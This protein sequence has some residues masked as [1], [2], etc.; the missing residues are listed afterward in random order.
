VPVEGD[1]N[2]VFHK[3]IHVRGLSIQLRRR[4]HTAS[5]TTTH[6]DTLPDQFVPLIG[7]LDLKINCHGNLS[8]LYLDNAHGVVHRSM[9]PTL[10]AMQVDMAS[11]DVHVDCLTDRI[12]DVMCAIVPVSEYIAWQAGVATRF[13][14]LC[15]PRTTCVSCHSDFVVTDDMLLDADVTT[16]AAVAVGTSSNG[17]VDARGLS[18]ALY[19]SA[20]AKAYEDQSFDCLQH[21]AKDLDRHWAFADQCADCRSRQKEPAGVVDLNGYIDGAQHFSPDDNTNVQQQPSQVRPQVRL[22]TREVI[23]AGMT[24]VE[25]FELSTPLAVIKTLVSQA[26]ALAVEMLTVETPSI[27]TDKSAECDEVEALPHFLQYF[28]GLLGS[29]SNAR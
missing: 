20:L 2:Q 23:W 16:S 5:D 17:K 3:L 8:H 10:V 12:E 21:V 26:R 15:E 22:A 6:Y 29:S 25:R 4:E 19:S 14:Q 1:S 27:V 11:V 13:E 24:W 18:R 9:C 7:P 28:S